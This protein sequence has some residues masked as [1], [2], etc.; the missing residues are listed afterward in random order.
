MPFIQG[1]NVD[2][3]DEAITKTI[4]VLARNMGMDIIAEGVE[5]QQQES[6]LAQ[7]MCDSMQGFYYYKP[8]PAKEIE[9][10]LRTNS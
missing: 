8:M 9:V 10:L 7:R 3:R 6:F 5:T 1:I 2:E 4:I